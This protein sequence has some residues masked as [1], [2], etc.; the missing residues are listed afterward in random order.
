MQA[1]PSLS[2]GQIPID[3][4]EKNNKFNFSKKADYSNSTA[5]SKAI[6]EFV[7]P[8]N[9]LE[10]GLEFVGGGLG[11]GVGKG[12]TKFSKTKLGKKLI[13]KL[14]W[15]RS[16]TK[17]ITTSSKNNMEFDFNK[18]NNYS[19]KQMG[20]GNKVKTDANFEFQTFDATVTPRNVT[21]ATSNKGV[22]LDKFVSK[23]DE[24]IDYSNSITKLPSKS[25]R[26]FVK[27]D[28]PNGNEQIFYKSSGGGGKAG[29]KGEWI[30]FE[31]FKED[32]W[33]VKTGSEGTFHGKPIKTVFTGKGASEKSHG[34]Y[35]QIK[36][37]G[38]DPWKEIEKGNLVIKE[39]GQ[40]FKYGSKE[41]S[42]ISEQLS[43]SL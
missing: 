43:K 32:G 24:P 37:L 29:S 18:K 22:D 7:T 31:G 9:N 27:V 34:V 33:F 15:L 17:P 14:P 6:T 13:S 1:D 26:D 21:R 2:G 8:Q 10:L 3:P 25:G 11:V 40:G 36:Q 42:K 12:V 39:W 41:Y 28:L 30:P 16:L 23:L 20:G 35:E 4:T 38:L 19:A 5:T